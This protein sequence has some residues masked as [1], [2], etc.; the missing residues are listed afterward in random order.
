MIGTSVA[1]IRQARLEGM[2]RAALETSPWFP[3]KKKAP[4]MAAFRHCSQ[5]GR[6]A[7]LDARRRMG[8]ATRKRTAA[9]E[10]GGSVSTATRM[11]RKVEP[12]TR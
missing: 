8:P 4:R 5:V 2:K 7:R 12:H 10:S 9:M 6:A 3:R 1:M 11:P